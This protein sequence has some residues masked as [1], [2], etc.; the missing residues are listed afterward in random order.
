MIIV[1]LSKESFLALYAGE[2]AEPAA[3][4]SSRRTSGAMGVFRVLAMK[5][6]PDNAL[7]RIP[8]TQN[9]PDMVDNVEDV[10]VKCR[11][12]GCKPGRS[13]AKVIA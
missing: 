4:D 12:S 3:V 2:D 10:V 7:R 8:V 1:G 5:K 9:V 13:R 11:A 6:Y